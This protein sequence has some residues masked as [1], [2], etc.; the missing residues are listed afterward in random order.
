MNA[1]VDFTDTVRAQVDA[2]GLR[3]VASLPDGFRDV[4]HVA[5]DVVVA[6]Q[7]Q[8]LQAATEDRLAWG[9]NF[10]AQPSM[11]EG[12]EEGGVTALYRVTCGRLSR[13]MAA[14]QLTVSGHH[15]VAN[16]IEAAGGGKQTPLGATPITAAG[17][18]CV[19]LVE[20]L[21]HYVASV[22]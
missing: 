4:Y 5:V 19:P 13:A 11:Q 21:L 22:M 3:W 17:A 15:V 16:A 18:D 1:L 9:N 8:A 14:L 10:A 20:A 6:A 2:R 12:D 7:P